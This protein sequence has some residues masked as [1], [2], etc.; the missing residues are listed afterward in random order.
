MQAGLHNRSI[1][2]QSTKT[3]NNN[4]IK[5]VAKKQ[6][7]SPNKTTLSRNTAPVAFTAAFLPGLRHFRKGEKDKGIV[8]MTTYAVMTALCCVGALAIF[9]NKEKLGY[10]LAGTGLVG[11]IT[12]AIISITDTCR[13]PSKK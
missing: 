9:K 3:F 13:K 1:Q 4:N 12:T 5:V 6:E 2:L 10:L 8:Y 11:A 7:G